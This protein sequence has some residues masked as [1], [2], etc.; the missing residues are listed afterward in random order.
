MRRALVAATSVGIALVATAC[1][2]SSR[3]TPQSPCAESALA[4]SPVGVPARPPLL[5]TLVGRLERRRFVS[6]SFTRVD[7]AGTANARCRRNHRPVP[8]RAMATI[9]GR[10]RL[11]PGLLA[12]LV[13]QLDGRIVRLRLVGGTEYADV[14]Q[15]AA[16]PPVAA[17]AGG[18]PWLAMS[19]GVHLKELLSEVD[20]RQSVRLIAATRDP[21]PLG[22]TRV[23]GIAVSG[24]RGVFDGAHPPTSAHAA[25]L[26][27]QVRTWLLR[28]R[29]SREV[30]TAYVTAS[31]RP[32]RVVT[33]IDTANSRSTFVTVEDV[34][35]LNI[36]VRMRPPAASKT[37]PISDAQARA[38]G[39]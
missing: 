38:L 19:P 34:R 23:D 39:F 30:V 10:V 4:A 16:V 24:F 20:P 13:D 8:C 14:S 1:G 12:S 17:L 32:V 3:G 18:R 35:A 25:G 2:G 22:E 15:F 37:R 27:S 28:R 11:A 26:V 33:A 21:Q 9:S 29:A 6:F 5:A 36:A 7:C 31:G